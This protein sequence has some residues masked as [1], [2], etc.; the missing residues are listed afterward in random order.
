MNRKEIVYNRATRDYAMY[1][2]GE[3]MGFERTYHSAEV[4]LDQLVFDMLM[5]GDFATAGELDDDEGPGGADLYAAAFE[6]D[7]DYADAAWESDHGSYNGKTPSSF[8]N[9]DDV[10][11]DAPDDDCP[12][13]GPYAD[14][15]CPKCACGADATLVVHVD[16]T[17]NEVCRIC[18]EREYENNYEDTRAW[19]VDPIDGPRYFLVDPTGE[20]PILTDI[21]QVLNMALG[22]TH[23]AA[24]VVAELQRLKA[25]LE[26]AAVCG[27]ARM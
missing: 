25:R 5:D 15:E 24:S 20:T 3:L 2:D 26:A 4:Q 14:D 13:H 19:I 17:D 23:G 10:P 7:D 11:A 6:D 21:L 8:T 1:L 27:A 22:N 18:F 12:D 9:S 16:H